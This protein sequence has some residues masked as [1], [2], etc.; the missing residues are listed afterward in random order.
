[1]KY[2]YDFHWCAGQKP[3]F[4]LPSGKVVL[5]EVDNYVPYVNEPVMSVATPAQFNRRPMMAIP[6]GEGG[7]TSSLSP[8][9]GGEANQRSYHL[10]F[11]HSFR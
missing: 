3:Y 2:G 1:M 6:A 5:L 4:K 7:S 11:D 9:N 8:G 10:Y